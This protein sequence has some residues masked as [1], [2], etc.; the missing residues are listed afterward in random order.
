MWLGSLLAKKRLH[1]YL[2]IF[3]FKAEDL[4]GVVN[5]LVDEGVF[6]HLA[7]GK[8]DEEVARH[9]VGQVG[10]HTGASPGFFHSAAVNLQEV[11]V[12]IDVHLAVLVL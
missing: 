4:V 5:V 11:Q 8:L 12:T 7:G 2:L 10:Q 3:D 1:V 9:I 6:Q